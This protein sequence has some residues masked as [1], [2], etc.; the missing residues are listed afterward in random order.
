[1]QQAV[2]VQLNAETPARERTRLLE[3]VAAN[4]QHW[5]ERNAETARYHDKS[6]RRKLRAAGIDLRKV[7]RCPLRI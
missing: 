1:M 3:K 5:Q 6:T 4:I 2:E 7:R